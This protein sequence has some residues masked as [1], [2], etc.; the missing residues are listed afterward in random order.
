MTLINLTEEEISRKEYFEKCA[1]QKTGSQALIDVFESKFHL[2]MQNPVN[3]TIIF[4]N[5]HRH[6]LHN[7]NLARLRE[8][9][10]EEEGKHIFGQ[11]IQEL[12]IT[13]TC[14][15]DYNYG[16]VDQMPDGTRYIA[17]LIAKNPNIEKIDLSHTQLGSDEAEIL[18]QALRK[19]TKLLELRLEGN[20]ISKKYLEEINN[21]LAENK[22]YKIDSNPTVRLKKYFDQSIQSQESSGNPARLFKFREREDKRE[23]AAKK[24]LILAHLDVVNEIKATIRRK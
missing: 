6:L 24:S 20:L 22:K 3:K 15:K 8:Y 23:V 12:I 1:S 18:L 16:C 5:I 11:T 10:S 13:N 7:G 14:L 19:N 9:F 2:A 4:D 17:E 21:K